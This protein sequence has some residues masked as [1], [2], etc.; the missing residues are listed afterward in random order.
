MFSPVPYA[1]FTV[2]GFSYVA[3]MRYFIPGVLLH[4]DREKQHITNHQAEPFFGR[5]AV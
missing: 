2:Q 5:N 3:C 4:D 1:V